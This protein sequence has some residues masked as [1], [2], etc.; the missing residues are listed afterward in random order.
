MLSELFAQLSG[1]NRISQSRELKAIYN[2]IDR[3]QAIIQFSPDGTILDAND[4]FCAVI[5]YRKDEMIGEH[6]RMLVDPTFVNSDEYTAMW[7]TINRG[8]YFAGEIKRLH[9]NGQE[10]WIQASYNPMFDQEGKLYKVIKFATDITAQKLRDTDF[11]SQVEA[12]GKSQA[13][14]QFKLDGTIVTANDNFCQL[15][16][17]QLSEIRGQH[18]RMFVPKELA[19]SDEYQAFWN[20][21]SRGEF[22]CAEFKRISK[23]GEEIWIQATYNPIFDSNGKPCKVV[24]FATDITN[25]K[26]LNLEYEGQLTAINKSQAVIEFELDGT[27]ISAN[28][29]FCHAFGYQR[30]EIQGQHHRI[31]TEPTLSHSKEYSQF[32]QKLGEGN[33][34][35]GEFKRIGKNGQEVWIQATYN[36]V[37]DPNGKPFKVVKF[38]TDITQEK[39]RQQAEKALRASVERYDFAM[40]VSG[41]II[42]DWDVT[43]NEVKLNHNWLHFMEH[44]NDNLLISYQEF[45]AAVHEDDQQA[46]TKRLV[47]CLRDDTVY[48]SNHRIVS[49]SGTIRY[50]ED[51]GTV[52]ARDKEGKATRFIA[53]AT[54]ITSL[55]QAESKLTDA[56]ERTRLLLDSVTDGVISLNMDGMITF[57]NPAA[58]ALLGY[59]VKELLGE[60]MHALAQHS[61][62]DGHHS[63]KEHGFMYKSTHDGG[64]YNIDNEIFWRK[65]G[66]N[67]QTEYTSVPIIKNRGIIGAVV[68]YRDITQ[69]KEIEL[70]LT[71]SKQIADDANQAKSDFLANM[72]HEIRTPMNAII[73]MS[74]LALDT[75]LNKKQRNYIEKVHRSAEALLGI[76]ND[77]LDFSKI[78]AGKLDIEFIPFR[79]EDVMD[80]L[81]NLVGLK[82]EESGVELHYDVMPNTPMALIGDP[83]RLGQILI[84]LGNNAV[85][86]TESG[87]EVVI[88]VREKSTVNDLIQLQF[89]IRDNGIGMTHEQKNKLFNS[90]SQ[91]DTSTTRKYGGT[92]LGLTICKKLINM[93]NGDIWVESEQGVGSTFSFTIEMHKQPASALTYDLSTT[94]LEGLRILVVDDNST[95]R[96]ILSQMLVQFGFRVDQAKEGNE[97]IDK[98]KRASQQ[99][100]FQLV[101]MDWR[102]PGKDGVTTAKE[103]QESDNVQIP[104]TIIMVTAYGREEATL[105]AGDIAISGLLTK[106]ITP[107]QM[108]DCILVAMGKEVIKHRNEE[109]NDKRASDAVDALAGANILLVEDNLMN[110]E[111]ATE[112]LTLN[113]MH[114]TLA[115]NGQQAIDILMARDPNYFDGILMDCQMPVMDGYSATKIIRQNTDFKTLPILAMTANAMAGDKE[116]VL[117]VGMN[118][119]IAKPI[120]VNDMF[121]AMASWI[122]P[123]NPVNPP[124]NQQKDND[125]IRIGSLPG[126]DVARGL[127]TTQQNKALYIKLL[128]RFKQS[129]QDFFQVFSQSLMQQ[130]QEAAVRLAHT[131]KGT[132]GNIGAMTVFSLAAKLELVAQDPQTGLDDILQALEKAL[133][134]V[135]IGLDMMETELVQQDADLKNTVNMVS[136]EKV[137]ELLELLQQQIEDFDTDASETLDELEPLIAIKALQPQFNSLSDAINAYDFETAEGKASELKQL[138]DEQNR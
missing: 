27:I 12:I 34:Q 66:S 47:K 9:K 5:G 85:K 79:L 90:F 93:M 56:E 77:I 61:D 11:R 134:E 15:M 64:I 108:L 98:V 42:W 62:A 52:V 18:H 36:P 107:S 8:E 65:D 39:R 130:D 129:N 126:I 21:L 115:E 125:D 135:L 3:V 23:T 6:H 51:R 128:R 43:H 25:Q 48:K 19:S 124:T 13:V 63:P 26:R 53:C 88:S 49:P 100:P 110:Q 81:A 101:L 122:T 29:N 89:D 102:M 138:W 60:Q 136:P 73:G 114:V 91:A 76:I 57:A 131:L 123:A 83:L 2:A 92:G 117:N 104:P 7:Q 72:S 31:F 112:L 14:I 86:F 38:A 105:A 35:T 50:M 95:A 68:V 116:K 37:F 103:I 24:K 54:D 58:A 97:A 55:K 119:H 44:A 67:F 69:R 118:D 74:H 120:S 133:S 132:S 78:E 32:W 10:I 87:G 137:T 113:N 30:E 109:K 46:V 70:Q 96:E 59:E 45:I 33:F 106:P 17:Y 1:K 82:A 111:L 121:I 16:G 75:A 127:A 80:N 28:D 71:H 20:R 41:H 40:D 94:D 4:N 84:N 22:E 99:D